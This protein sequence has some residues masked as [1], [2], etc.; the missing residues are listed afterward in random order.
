MTEQ[1]V[2]DY[3]TKNNHDQFVRAW[4]ELGRYTDEVKEYVE[5]LEKVGIARI[6]NRK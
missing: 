5:K 4:K 3:S 2:K 1:L 6:D